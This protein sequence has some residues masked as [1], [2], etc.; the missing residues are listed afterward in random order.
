MNHIN[1]LV[2]GRWFCETIRR[3]VRELPEFAESP[4]RVRFDHERN[5]RTQVF[6][7]HYPKPYFGEM[8]LH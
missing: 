1:T 6:A 7:Q 3:D 8:P 4:N 2:A 5:L